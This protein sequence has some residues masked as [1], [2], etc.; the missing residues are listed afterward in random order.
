MKRLTLLQ[1]LYEQVTMPF[2]PNH[3]DLPSY[4]DMLKDPNY[5][6]KRKNKEFKVVYMTP[7]EYV[8]H[9]ADG[10]KRD[11]FSREQLVSSRDTDVID[12]YAQ[13]M[14]NGEKFPMLM[15]DHSSRMGFDGKKQENFGQEGLHRALAAK[16]AGVKRIPVMIVRDAEGE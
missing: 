15:I 6:R 14:K 5:F 11:G 12:R 7:D 9:A 1:E 4:D 3:T 10:F 2:D 13:K 8:D 16:K